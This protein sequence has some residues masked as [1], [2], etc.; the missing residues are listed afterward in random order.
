MALFQF[1]QQDIKIHSHSKNE[2][3]PKKTEKIRRMKT[4]IVFTCRTQITETDLYSSITFSTQ[5]HLETFLC[6]TITTI[7]SVP[8]YFYLRNTVWPCEAY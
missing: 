8:F 4:R 5:N 1:D 7:N 2:N 6:V 3:E